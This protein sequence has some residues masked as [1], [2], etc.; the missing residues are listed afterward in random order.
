MSPSTPAPTTTATVSPIT[1]APTPITITARP[2]TTLPTPPLTTNVST[3]AA[4]AF[5]PSNTSDCDYDQPAAEYP[6]DANSGAE[7][8]DTAPINPASYRLNGQ[9]ASRPMLTPVGSSPGFRMPLRRGGVRV[10][11]N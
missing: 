3:V 7:C 6:G 4:T 5:A 8:N 1:P 11:I 9:M 10:A 2:N